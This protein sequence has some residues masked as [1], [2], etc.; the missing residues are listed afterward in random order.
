[1]LLH[2]PHQPQA[3]GAGADPTARRLPPTRVIIQAP[4]DLRL[5][6]ALLSGHQPPDRLHEPTVSRGIG[7]PIAPD[8]G[9]ATD[10]GEISLGDTVC[11]AKRS[12]SEA[13]DAGAPAGPCQRSGSLVGAGGRGLV[14]DE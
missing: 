7:A 5:V 1:P 2:A 10:G 13:R 6:V 11:G 8:Y 14:G 3:R 4:P 9:M 12:A